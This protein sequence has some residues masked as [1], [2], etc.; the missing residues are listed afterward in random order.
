M[1]FRFK[2]R[3]WELNKEGKVRKFEGNIED[4]DFKIIMRIGL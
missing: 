4:R 3:I 2:R 1:I